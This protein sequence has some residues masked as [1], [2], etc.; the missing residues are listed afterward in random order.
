[1]G[2]EGDRSHPRRAL[3]LLL[4]LPLKIFLPRE[5]GSWAVLAAPVVVGFCAARGGPPLTQALF[6][7]A[8]LG[9]FLLRPALAAF[10]FPKPNED[11]AWPSL[12]FAGAL[13]LG[14][15]APLFLLYDRA[16]LAWFAL[17]AAVLLIA[18][19]L[20]RRGRRSFGL[21]SELSGILILCLGAPAAIYAARGVMS[22]DAWWV[23]L[24]SALFFSGPIFHVKLA[25]LQH[26]ASVDPGLI[27]S[28][29]RARTTGAIYHAA[30]LLIAAAGAV[31][32]PVPALATLPF[33]AAL[34]KNLRRGARPPAKV[35]F[36][37]LG[38]QEVGYS[39]LF[40][41]TVSAGYLLR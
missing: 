39:V 38:Y 33:A 13:A 2:A 16:G 23:W 17:P 26:R 29:P 40:A 22:A 11:G 14:G 35:D 15:L 1:M 30:A 27:G 19:L 8:A 37:A 5:H 3:R 12:I 10:F 6:C 4:R 9:G 7:C 21:F 28:L 41:L 18:D 36:R 25:A 24:L 20:L 34:I 32:G 31:L